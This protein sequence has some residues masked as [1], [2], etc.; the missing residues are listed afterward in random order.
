MV[1]VIG[2]NVNK[3]IAVGGGIMC[4]TSSLVFK[5]SRVKGLNSSMGGLGVS[6]TRKSSSLIPRSDIA[7]E[8]MSA[9][10]SNMVSG[11]TPSCRDSSV[12]WLAR[13]IIVSVLSNWTS[14]K[15][16]SSLIF[17]R[18]L[19][20]DSSVRCCI[21]DRFS[22][23]NIVLT[24]STADSWEGGRSRITPSLGVVLRITR[25]CAG[26]TLGVNQ[27]S[28]WPDSGVCTEP[29]RDRPDSW[30]LASEISWMGRAYLCWEWVLWG[31]VPESWGRG[32]P[33]G[34]RTPDNW[35]KIIR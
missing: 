35:H 20:T 24:L 8:L 1:F 19:L 4:G 11:R 18:A 26:V 15:T 22:S 5:E 9:N 16:G 25:P 28:L 33:N 14:V 7:R 32:D 3:C 27:A 29:W 13:E 34:L 6:E 21:D 2:L 10:C 23:S 30:L 12:S 31:W 17:C